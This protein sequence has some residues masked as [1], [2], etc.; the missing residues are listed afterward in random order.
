[1][2]VQRGGEVL[3]PGTG[4][5]STQ[6]IDARDLVQFIVRLAENDVSGV[7]NATG[8][9]SRLSMAEMLYGIRAVTNNPVSFTWVPADFLTEQ[10]VAPWGDMPCWIPGHA[11]MNVRLERAIEAGITYRPLAETVADT[12]EWHA[13][14]DDERRATTRAGLSEEREAEVLAAWHT[15]ESGA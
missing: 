1:M 2:R 9:E 10:S 3:A 11:V 14:L 6:V 8:P 12:L 15:R 4:R 13:G 5:D 7:F